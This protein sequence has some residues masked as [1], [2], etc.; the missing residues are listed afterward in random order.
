MA[1]PVAGFH[2]KQ[3]ANRQLVVGGAPMH[4]AVNIA[5]AWYSDAQLYTL[6]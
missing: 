1:L 4:T 2:V 3:L 5:D 6:P